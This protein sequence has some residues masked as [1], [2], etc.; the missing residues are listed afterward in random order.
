MSKSHVN[1]CIEFEF[2]TWIISLVLK[3]IFKTSIK[4]LQQ[5]YLRSFPN[6]NE[7]LQEKTG[8][9]EVELLLS[10][11]KLKLLLQQG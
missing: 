10:G 3:D 9:L 2:L 5:L 4:T 7:Q 1:S 8:L 11:S 6:T